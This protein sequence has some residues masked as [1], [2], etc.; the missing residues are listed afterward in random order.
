MICLKAKLFEF[1][2]TSQMVSIS[3]N[4]KV[5]KLGRP[6]IYSRYSQSPD[7]N[8]LLVSQY[9]KPFSYLVPASRFPLLT[10]I[11]TPRGDLIAQVA[12]LPS[13]ENIPKGFD[14]VI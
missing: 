12:D 2:T 3:L 13:G 11:W 9:Q 10:E 6:A 8:Y 5:Q 4:G 7:G 1:L 14:S